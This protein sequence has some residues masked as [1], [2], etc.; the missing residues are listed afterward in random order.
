[1]RS[2]FF[3]GCSLAGS[4]PDAA[5]R[6]YRELCQVEPGTGVLMHCCGV[7]AA[8]LGMED[9]ARRAVRSIE[10]HVER[11]GADELVVVCP[12][13]EERLAAE[14]EHVK[15]RTVWE[16]LTDRWSPPAPRAETTMTVHDPCSARHKPELQR[17]VRGLVRLAG[18]NVEEMEFSRG[19]TRC[20]GLG[21][22]IAPVD[23]SLAADIGRRRAAECEHPVVTYCASCRIALHNAGAEPIDLA[24]LLLSDDAATAARRKPPGRMI[25]YLNRLRLKRAFLRMHS[26][27]LP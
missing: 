21:G 24:V 12:G 15:V 2:L 7:P 4:A 25:R 22:R 13:C 16:H 6:L 1:V 14:L 3:T 9:E 23:P 5:L 18:G 27:E 8:A 26:S 10:E 11:L 20:C 17:A 19:T